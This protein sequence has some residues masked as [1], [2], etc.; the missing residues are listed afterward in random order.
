[1]LR[2]AVEFCWSCLRWLL[3]LAVAGVVVGAVYLHRRVDEEVRLRVEREIAQYYPGLKV[4]VRRA[5]LID[6]EGIELRGVAI[7]EPGADGPR[8]ELVAVDEMFLACSTDWRELFAGRTVVRRILLRR[9]TCRVTRR[10]DG[11]WTTDRMLP[12]PRS[13]EEAPEIRVENGVVEVFDPT[14]APPAT[15]TL[16][17]LNMTTGPVGAG[18][19]IGPAAHT[20][21]LQGTFSA[22]HVR[23]ASFEGWIDLARRHWALTG[24]VEGAE[25]GPELYGALP[26]PLGEPLAAAR[27]LRAQSDFQ[28]RVAY[29]PAGQ[30][31]YRY[32]LAAKLTRGRLDHA[33]L[34]Y[35]LTDLKADVVVDESGVMVDS[36]AARANQ[37]S[38]RLSARRFGHGAAAPMSVVAEIRQ[39]EIDQPLV[40]ALPAWLRDRWYDCRPS[41]LIDADV[42][43][44]F[45]GTT[46]RPDIT[47]QCLN[48]SATHYWFPYRVDGAKGTVSLKDDVLRLSLTAS[49]GAQPVR[50]EAE[51]A[52]A[53]SAPVGW[54]EAKGDGLPIDATLL[55]ALSKQTRGV[56]ESLGARGA[57]NFHARLWQNRPD[58]PLHTHLM[59]A[60]E[61]CSFQP[62]WFP[63]PF[64][65][66]RGTIE[67]IDGC[68]NFRRWE[69]SN[70]S[71][72]F[73]CEGQLTPTIKGQRLDLR[74]TGE[75]VPLDEELR[76][77]LTPGQRQVWSAFRPRGAVDF[78]ADLS[79]LAETEQ[80][81]VELRAE[82]RSDVTSIEMVHFPYRMERLEGL[83]WY[84]DG[85][86]VLS[87]LRAEHGPVRLVGDAV[88]DFL[89][90]GQWRLR[91]DRLFVDR[92]SLDR[93][94][95]QALP[96][97]IRRILSEWKI[98]GPLNLSGGVE[99][100]RGPRASDPVH[101]TW[102]IVAG[103]HQ[104]S[105]ECGTH[106][107]NIC[108]Q[109]R[110]RGG[111]DGD[112]FHSSG[113]LAIDS[114]S[115]H[116]RQF[117]EIAGPFW[118]DENQ[119][120]LGTGAER[121]AAE[122]GALATNAPRSH[123]AGGADSLPATSLAG[124]APREPPATAPRRITGRLFGGV[125]RADGWVTFG[126][127]PR[128]ALAAELVDG[129]L[130]RCA[131]EVLAGRQD[132]RGAIRASV[133][134][135]GRGWT[136]NGLTG[137]GT[138]RLSEADVYELPVMVSL[139]KL[140]SIRRPDKNAFSH[141]DVDFRI[142][143]EH[144]YFDR[145]DFTGDAVSLLGKGEMDFQRAVALR[146]HAV[147]GRAQ[148]KVPVLSDLFAGASKQIMV[149][150]VT[151][152]LDDPVVKRQ[153]FPAVNQAITLLQEDRTTAG[154][155]AR[156]PLGRLAPPRTAHGDAYSAPAGR[157]SL[158]R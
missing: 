123:R 50:L 21:R 6:G 18:Q 34:P 93:E 59:V 73:F 78:A 44:D 114:M 76:D 125:L 142:E 154:S 107:E 133:K 90:D 88:C 66:V 30:P 9:P 69:A 70:D 94:L 150:Q 157:T 134:L 32:R 31:E 158:K 155:E 116:D 137:H 91:F 120:V 146:F 153:P 117:T 43:L 89:P 57:M 60:L 144:F 3:L 55:A 35:P 109:V 119:L 135:R 92:V 58:E 52:Q 98:T 68:W 130:A 62:E 12:A 72:R 63:Y 47:V 111:S 131:Q 115:F 25:L 23:L 151:G 156:P 121:I 113:E 17:D 82:P 65:N 143:G 75:N 110:L 101:S 19:S 27:G 42:K 40:A 140:L 112:R 11:R 132:L 41:G 56:I 10:A 99:L 29:D 54:F 74:L 15:W 48:V 79:Y 106:L 118:I 16:R 105:L 51:I 77:A 129:D 103:L 7:V 148:K 81:T 5:K 104:G 147:V 4:S 96:E 2:R 136:T 86:V 152:T 53:T 102:D 13:G 127:E 33:A 139:L 22:D 145:I 20:R 126:P 100:V 83:L 64:R 8:A 84:R 36:L 122:H 26:S 95:I 124:A 141:A 45:D 97:R 87:G 108:G 24:A 67:M 38:L 37:A 28:F 128:Y 85:R 46:W 149:I 14:R 1:M 39:L 71:G 138:I 61:R 80:M 49:A